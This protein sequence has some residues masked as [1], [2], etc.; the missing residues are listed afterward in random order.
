M[1][2]II[3]FLRTI[4]EI[5]MFDEMSNKRISIERPDF[6]LVITLFNNG[7]RIEVLPDVIV[8]IE[9][10]IEVVHYL[11]NQINIEIWNEIDE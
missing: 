11:Q 7:F 3:N 8:W 5:M 6:K 1:K 2:E 4:F 9:T 10:E